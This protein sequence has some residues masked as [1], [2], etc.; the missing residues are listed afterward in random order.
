MLKKSLVVGIVFLFVFSTVTSMVFGYNEE[1]SCSSNEENKI[2]EK[3]TSS[4]GPVDSPWPMKCHDN[5]H[6]GT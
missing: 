1:S 2:Y 5:R 4:S 6:T 3:V